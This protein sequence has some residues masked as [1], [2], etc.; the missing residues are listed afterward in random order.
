MPY[1]GPG[2]LYNPNV[3]YTSTEAPPADPLVP[4]APTLFLNYLV[5]A[6]V[7]LWSD[8]TAKRSIV[9]PK[10][11]Y[12]YIVVGGGSAGAIIAFEIK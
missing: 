2:Y 3:Y 9:K 11:S 6:A 5:A 10:S 7:Y 12:D 4:I 8:L 1:P